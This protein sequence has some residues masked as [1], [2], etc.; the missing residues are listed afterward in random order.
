M[1]WGVISYTERIP[2]QFYISEGIEAGHASESTLQPMVYIND[3]M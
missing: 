3:V 2:E 1:A